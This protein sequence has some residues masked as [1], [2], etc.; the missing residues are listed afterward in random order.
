MPGSAVRIGLVADTH[1]LVRPEC[2]Q[3]LGGV[4]VILHA[5]DVGGPHVLAALAALAPVHA[6]SGNVDPAGAPDLATR[7]DLVFDGVSVHVSH[8]DELGSPT[9]VRLVERYDADVIVFGH[10]HRPVIERIGRQL[11][12]NPGAAGP[13]RF[14]LTPSIAVLIIEH[15]ESR[16][17]LVPLVETRRSR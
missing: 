8:G 6:V 11:V 15:G 14:H 1:G 12:V 5:G 3:A 10:T 2:L 7:L 13:G 16:A 17:T 9:P 4:D